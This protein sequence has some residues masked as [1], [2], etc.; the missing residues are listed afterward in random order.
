MLDIVLFILQV[1]QLDATI[2][3]KQSSGR[4][5]SGVVHSRDRDR[6]NKARNRSI[7]RSLMLRLM[8]IGVH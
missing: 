2:P 6:K 3:Q 7:Y 8:L 5:S 1:D 4:L